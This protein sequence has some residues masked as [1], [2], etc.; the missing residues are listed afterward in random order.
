MSGSTQTQP[1][2]VS[3]VVTQESRPVPDPTVLTTQQ[4]LRAIE[5]AEDKASKDNQILETRIDGMK[6]LYTEKFH[7]VDQRFESAATALKAALEAAKEAVGKTEA[8]VAKTIEE[9]Q[10]AKQQSDKATDDKISD[11]KDRLTAIESRSKGIGDSWAVVVAVIGIMIALATFA[12]IYSSH[13]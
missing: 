2:A 7:G 10:K 13:K 5:N 4:L 1:V 3:P 8:S 12:V 9:Q 6:E 11:V